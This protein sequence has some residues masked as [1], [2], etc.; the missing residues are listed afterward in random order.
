MDQT[1]GDHTSNLEGGGIL[2]SILYIL[3]SILYIL[4]SILYILNSSL[5]I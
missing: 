3:N 2:N 4:N 1:R 5:Y